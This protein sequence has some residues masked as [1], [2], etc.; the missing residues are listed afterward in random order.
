MQSGGMKARVGAALTVGG[1]FCVV[2]VFDDCW[3]EALDI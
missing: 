2:F 3:A 1:V